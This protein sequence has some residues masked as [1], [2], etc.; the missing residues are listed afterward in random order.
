MDPPIQIYHE[1]ER[2]RAQGNCTECIVD[3]YTYTRVE[4]KRSVVE[5]KRK[6]LTWPWIIKNIHEKGFNLVVP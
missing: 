5:Q 4:E 1:R 2:N 3:I 6:R